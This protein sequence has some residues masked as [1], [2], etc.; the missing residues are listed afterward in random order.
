MKSRRQTSDYGGDVPNFDMSTHNFDARPITC[1]ISDRLIAEVRVQHEQDD[2][3]PDVPLPKTFATSKRHTGVTAQELSERWLI[4]LT[5]AH[6]TQNCA[7][8]AVLQLSRRYRADRVFEKPL[9]RGDFYTDT[10]DGRCKSINGNKYAQV[11]AN[12]DFFAYSYPLTS[13]SEAGDALRQFIQEFGRPEKMTYDGSQEQCGRKTEFTKNV[14]KYSINYHTTEP[15][16]P[17]HNFA[18]GVIREVRKKWFRI[19]VR[20]NV[21]QRL[22]DY[23]LQWVCDIQNRTS[24]SSR[25]LDGRCPLEKLTGETVDISEYLDFG[26]YDWVWYRENAGLGETKIG[27]WL[28]VSHRVGTLMSFWVL[29]STGK[30]LSRTTVQRMTQLEMQLDENKTRVKG[31]TD[32]LTERIG[33]N[34]VVQQ[35]DGGNMILNIDDWDDPAFDAEIVQEFGRVINDPEIKEADDDLRTLRVLHPCADGTI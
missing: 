32:K 21:P 24:N 15:Y 3:P 7:R 1:V 4:G 22:W 19:M 28:G 33:G 8:S 27:R 12:K 31:Y 29:A 9:L 17:N 13:K 10:M 20:K 30:V 6:E 35:D 34:D 2:L 16:R 26:F 5:Q 14:R 23:G 11:F 18:E 25:G